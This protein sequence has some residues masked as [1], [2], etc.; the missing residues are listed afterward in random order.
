MDEDSS[1][2]S[3]DFPKIKPSQLLR[4]DSNLLNLSSLWSAMTHTQSRNDYTDKETQT[5]KGY[6]TFPRLYQSVI[7]KGF[8]PIQLFTTKEE[9]GKGDQ[10]EEKKEEE[11]EDIEYL[12]C[13]TTSFSICESEIRK[14]HR[15]HALT[16]GAGHEQIVRH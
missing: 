14:V 6:V 1:K 9:A 3:Q 11:E 16:E 15:E 12:F 8:K 7:G 13:A 5:Q 10:K 2:L 4:K